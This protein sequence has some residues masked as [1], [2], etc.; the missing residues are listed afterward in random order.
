MKRIFLVWG[1]IIGALVF[2]AY[3]ICC[4][5]M[6]VIYDKTTKAVYTASEKDD[7]VVPENCD[8]KIVSGSLKE[9]TDENPTNYKLSGTKF[10]KDIAKIDAQ[11]Q[12]KILLEQK[13][14]EEKLI[15][16]KIRQQAID[17]LKA[18]GV[19]FKHQDK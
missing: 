8:K 14:A 11:E 19:V 5:E 4:A 17:T 1:L 3:R 15:Q 12:E 16:D 13:A 6:V 18:E 7:T 2:F 9:F 10:V